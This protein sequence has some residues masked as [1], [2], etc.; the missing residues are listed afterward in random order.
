MATRSSIPSEE[1][2]GGLV[3]FGYFLSFGEILEPMLEVL[4]NTFHCWQKLV[5]TAKGGELN[6]G[7]ACQMNNQQ[8][9]I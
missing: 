4:W 8:W 2:S 1:G 6:S 7:S 3:K 5:V 9:C